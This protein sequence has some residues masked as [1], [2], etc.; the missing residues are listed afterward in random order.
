MA[1]AVRRAMVLF[2]SRIRQAQ[3]LS[4]FRKLTRGGH[5]LKMI[6]ESHGVR[7]RCS[8]SAYSGCAAS[9]GTERIVRAFM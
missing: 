1:M 6:L 2:D 9:E 5:W 8:G 3:T 4:I 7:Y